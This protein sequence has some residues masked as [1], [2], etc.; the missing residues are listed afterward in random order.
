MQESY[1][2]NSLQGQEGF[3]LSVT[4][5]VLNLRESY[6]GIVEVVQLDLALLLA[7]TRYRGD[8]EDLKKLP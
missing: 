5:A 4:P 3:K 6:R 2:S 7:G 1:L 8:F